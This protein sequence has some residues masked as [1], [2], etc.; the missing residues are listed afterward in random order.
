MWT[1]LSIINYI[2]SLHYTNIVSILTKYTSDISTDLAAVKTN[3]TA[4]ASFNPTSWADGP[5]H[6]IPTPFGGR[7]VS[8]EHGSHY[9]AQQM[10]ILHN[11][12]LR[13]LVSYLGQ[14]YTDEASAL[15]RSSRTQST[16][17]HL[18]SNRKRTSEH[19][20]NL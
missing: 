16:I 10:S 2:K 20:S 7:D 19:S 8:K 17:K 12:I 18:T 1:L 15:T 5:F 9:L 11:C 6:L 4:M 14:H 3:I 13:V